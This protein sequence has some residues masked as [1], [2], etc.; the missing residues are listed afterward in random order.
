MAA[1][2]R[3]QFAYM[4]KYTIDGRARPEFLAAYAPD[5]EWARLFARDPGYLRTELLCDVDVEGQYLTIDYWVSKVAR[6]DFRKH[7]A[8][9]F[10][11]LDRRCEAFTLT[12]E[13][14]GDF[15]VAGDSAE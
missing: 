11:S 15:E 7:H 6:D 12:E 13:C 10:E 4:W 5:G 14:L 3:R 9:E 1:E 8:A 2:A